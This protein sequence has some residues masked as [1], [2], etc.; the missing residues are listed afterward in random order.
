[1]RR[2]WSAFDDLVGGVCSQPGDLGRDGTLERSG[3]TAL[4]I[5]LAMDG[6]SPGLSLD[7]G[8]AHGLVL[9]QHAPWAHVA[10]SC[11]FFDCR[12][13]LDDDDRLASCPDRHLEW[14]AQ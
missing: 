6:G 5:N 7:R 9:V 10:G 1:M 12:D 3:V 8:A 13:G 14:L 4:R 2:V 11:R